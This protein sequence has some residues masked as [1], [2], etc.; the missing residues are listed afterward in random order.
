MAK[1]FRSVAIICIAAGGL[2]LV[3]GTVLITQGSVS[4][5]DVFLMTLGALLI[6]A[7]IVT[8]WLRGI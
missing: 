2:T 1:I 5:L 6:V 8:L 4:V 3:G 7:G